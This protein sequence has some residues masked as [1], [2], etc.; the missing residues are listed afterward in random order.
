MPKIKGSMIITGA[1]GFIGRNLLEMFKDEY[2]IFAIA[3]RSQQECNAIVHE[4]I[5]WLRADISDTASLAQAFREIET[6]GGADYLLHL[7]AY[8]DFTDENRELYQRTNIEGTRN[9]LDCISGLNLKLFLFFSSVAACSFPPAGEYLDETSPPDGDHI[10][11]WS[12]RICEEMIQARQEQL[13]SCIIRLGAVFS[14]W[15][16]YPP[17]YRFLN[18]WLGKSWQSRILGGKGESAIPYVHVREVGIFL[19]QVIKEREQL[20]PAQIVIASTSG[21]TTHRELYD[22]ACHCHQGSNRKPILMPRLLSGF[23]LLMMYYMGRLIGKLP[24]ERPWMYHYIDL[25]LN[26]SNHFTSQLLKWQPNPRLRIERRM[27]HLVEHLKSETQMWHIRNLAALERS[28]HRPELLV[29]QVLTNHE[30][31]IFNHLV[32]K[33]QDEQNND[34]SRF[35]TVEYTDLVWFCRLIFRL[36]ASS[37]H[38]GNRMLILNYFEMTGITRLRAGYTVEEIIYLLNL[39]N[40]TVLRQ[41]EKLPELS[42][43]HHEFHSL[44]EVPIEFGIDEIEYQYSL[45]NDDGTTA[46]VENSTGLEVSPDARA[47]LEETIWKCLVHRNQ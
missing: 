27:P 32:L 8:Y 2:R 17:L 6:A 24:F 10:Y 30:N 41:L 31:D 21:S 46:S 33:L 19:H 14:D 28:Q 12:K 13:P 25:K 38:T 5:A 22:I 29:Y 37:L 39:V 26:V 9:L 20:A 15:C 43:Y 4:N 16:E 11:A 42:D 23:G 1:S 36:L 7:A 44:V 47:Q 45:S 35:S 40:E 18:T 34:T 3:R